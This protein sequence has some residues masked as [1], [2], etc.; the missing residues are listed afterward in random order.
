[1]IK[2]QLRSFTQFTFFINRDIFFIIALKAVKA[3]RHLPQQ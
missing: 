2:S 1:M 3:G